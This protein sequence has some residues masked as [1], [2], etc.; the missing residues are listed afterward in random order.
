MLR[1]RMLAVLVL[2]SLL[3]V[4]QNKEAPPEK[5]TLTADEYEILSD[6]LHDLYPKEKVDRVV[7]INQTGAGVPPGMAAM[8]QF[9]NKA[10][11]FLKEIPKE[12]KDGFQSRNRATAQIDRGGLK[13]DLEIVVLAPDR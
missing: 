13:A 7:L 3:A 8:T 6:A 5:T 11:E 1:V 4:A 12:M 10:Q 9:G 2:L